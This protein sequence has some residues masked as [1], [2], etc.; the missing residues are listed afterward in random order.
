MESKKRLNPNWKKRI[1]EIGKN[2]FELEECY[3]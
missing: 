2:N 3:V 1:K